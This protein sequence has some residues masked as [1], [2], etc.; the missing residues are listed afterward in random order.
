MISEDLAESMSAGD[1]PTLN[2]QKTGGRSEEEMIKMMRAF[3]GFRQD[4]L[5]IYRNH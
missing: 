2:L 3:C 1:R 4:S 5:T